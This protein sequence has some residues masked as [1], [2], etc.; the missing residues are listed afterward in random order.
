MVI[1][2]RPQH[3]GKHMML[4]DL[5]GINVIS[6]ILYRS[7]IQ[8]YL[9][10]RVYM[11]VGHAPIIND[12]DRVNSVN[13]KKKFMARTWAVAPWEDSSC[14][15]Q[16]VIGISQLIMM[17]SSHSLTRESDGKK[18]I[19]RVLSSLNQNVFHIL[20]VFRQHAKGYTPFNLERLYT[21]SSYSMGRRRKNQ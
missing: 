14:N 9:N 15:L 18:R 21:T 16:P 7:I 5:S 4:R 3:V 10:T 17:N 19:F 6:H 12:S 1:Y 13:R 2:F 8:M 20:F 11:L